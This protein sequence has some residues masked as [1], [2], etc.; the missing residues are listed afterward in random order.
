MFR[1]C[2]KFL[3]PIRERPRHVRTI[4]EMASPPVDISSAPTPA[5]RQ[6]LRESASS[7][8]A[9]GEKRYQWLERALRAIIYDPATPKE[10]LL[11]TEAELMAEFGLSRQTVRHAMDQL[12]RSGLIVRLAGRGT[13]IASQAQQPKQLTEFIARQRLLS[14]PPEAQFELIV[15]LH[16]RIDL[17]TAGRLQLPSDV[18]ASAAFRRIQN[19]A[20]YG[21]TSVFLPPHLG[22]LLA[23]AD[24]LVTEGASTHTTVAGLLDARIP[25]GIVGAD[26]SITATGLPA[27]AAAGLGRSEGDLALQID[28]MF[29]DSDGRVVELQS[30]YF[31]PQSYSYR[32]R[33]A[34]AQ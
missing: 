26:E 32:T 12:S 28:I 8:P 20:A 11:P 6:A 33:F 23:D 14:S 17:A 19:D 3:S 31:L 2:K 25:G 9:D 18:V 1:P 5:I 27:D 13:F 15:P 30:S 34:R 29:F 10:A 22:E 7:G 21:Y 4:R 24:E 16:T